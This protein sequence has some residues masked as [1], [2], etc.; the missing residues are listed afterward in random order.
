MADQQSTYRQIFKATSIFGGV[1]V[2]QILMNIIKSK[3]IA[4]LLGPAGIGML[5]LLN[6][7]IDMLK[8]IS[9]LGLE[10]GAVKEVSEAVAQ[11][12]ETA[13][14]KTLKVLRRCVWFTGLAGLLLTLCFSPLISQWTFG[15]KSYTW[16]FAVLSIVILL[17]AISTG[18]SAA[19]QGMRRITHLAKA[20]IL[21]SFFALLASLPL[22]YFFPDQSI[23]LFILI[24]AVVVL[25]FSTH[26]ARKIKTVAV[27]VSKDETLHQGW[28]MAKLGLAMTLSGAFSIFAAYLIKTYITYHSGIG[29]AGLYQSAF[30]IAEGYFGLIFAAMATDY[31]PRLAAIN[32]DYKLINEEVNK[33]TEIGMLIALPCILC[34]LF[35]M[36]LIVRL[37]Y[38]R[39]FLGSMECMK[40]ILLGNIFKI[41][42]WSMSYVLIATGKS[43]IFTLSN[44]LSDILY[45]ALVFIGYRLY[46][47]DG[48]GIAFLLYYILFFIA[49]YIITRRLFDL[50]YFSGFWK[51][52][53]VAV[54]LSGLSFYLQG[55]EN[56]WLKYLSAIIIITFG[57]Y[58]ALSQLNKRMDLKGFI[59]QKIKRNKD[60]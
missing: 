6:S 60:D 5:G 57:G 39:E 49:M 21:G 30:S 48:I 7:T 54:V 19:L 53:I 38:S 8:S 4:L 40:W 10:T 46:G 32:K 45:V 16:M 13:L 55:A 17:D 9:G 23:V 58:Y 26:Y 27:R 34:A 41:C 50:S 2:F 11:N 43:I 36:P 56:F 42:S 14:A 1:Q 37:L 29:E 25:I 20:G 15:N 33:Q 51:I 31:F 28:T 52:F 3:I 22:F 35:F 12:D 47:L 59:T 24:S 44:L 18:Q